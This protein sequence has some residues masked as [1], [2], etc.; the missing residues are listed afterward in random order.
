M[1]TLEQLAHQN[2]ERQISTLKFIRIH[3][4][5]CNTRPLY[6]SGS[7]KRPLWWASTAKYRF[8]FDCPACYYDAFHAGNPAHQGFQL[9]NVELSIIRCHFKRVRI[10]G[11]QLLKMR[12]HPLRSCPGMG[13][14]PPFLSPHQIDEPSVFPPNI[15]KFPPQRMPPRQHGRDRDTCAS[16]P[17]S[18]IIETVRCV[19]PLL[20]P[21]RALR[22]T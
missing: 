15:L 8:A 11:D 21:W 13:Q 7:C 12:G 14:S 3:G 16:V 18:V 19:P 6:G 20:R 2:A 10:A 9:M 4:W 17:L 5:A 22:Y 1:A